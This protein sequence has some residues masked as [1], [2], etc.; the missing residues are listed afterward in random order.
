VPHDQ[1]LLLMVSLAV[2]REL[3]GA[4][5]VPVSVSR[6]V[7]ALVE[8]SGIEVRRTAASA[9]AISAA[10]SGTG[11]L[12]AGA[13][14]GGLAFGAFLA[15]YDASAALCRLL[16]WLAPETTPVSQLVAE[17]PVSTLVHDQTPCPWAAKGA[18]MRR[19]IEEAK[20]RES[21]SVDGLLVREPNG[22]VQLLPDPDRPLFHVF[23]EATDAHGSRELADAYLAQIGEIVSEYAATR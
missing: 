4:I 19:L 8:G 18:V 2:R 21:E 11:V 1:V 3:A 23:A 15:A 6:Q 14:R 22:W 20:G 10:A 5:A 17:L 12:F 13:D 9:G 7:D 16:E